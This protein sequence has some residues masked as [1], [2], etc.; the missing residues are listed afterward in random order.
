M[1]VCMLCMCAMYMRIMFFLKASSKGIS[2]VLNSR[3]LVWP[4]RQRAHTKLREKETFRQEVRRGFGPRLLSRN[5]SMLPVFLACR[6]LKPELVCIPLEK[7]GADLNRGLCTGP[8][9][10]SRYPGPP[11]LSSATSGVLNSSSAFSWTTPFS[12]WLPASHK[13][14]PY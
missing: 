9:K 11:A 1:S 7:S 5:P 12:S 4:H 13:R 8:D 10:A 14:G 6:V 2:A 3:V